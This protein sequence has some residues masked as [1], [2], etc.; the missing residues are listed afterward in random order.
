MLFIIPQNGESTYT[1]AFGAF[2][3]IPTQ[4]ALEKNIPL[5]L[6]GENSAYEYGGAKSYKGKF[7]DNK[8]R[9]AGVNEGK[10]IDYWVNKN[11]KKK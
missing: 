2:H 5:I 1:Y 10:S 4:I 9:K 11:F 8:W 3:A 6:W 7:M